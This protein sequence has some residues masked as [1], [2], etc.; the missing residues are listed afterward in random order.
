[1]RVLHLT[2]RFHASQRHHA[3]RGTPEYRAV[4]RVIRELV[5]AEQLP[6]AQDV[7]VNIPPTLWCTGRPIPSAGLVVCYEV[8]RDGS[9]MIHGVQLA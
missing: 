1:M 4:A 2:R 5:R 6:E 9:L 8:R 3:P 7:E